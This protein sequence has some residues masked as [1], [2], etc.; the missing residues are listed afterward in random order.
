MVDD[1]DGEMKTWLEGSAFRTMELNPGDVMSDNKIET[2]IYFDLMGNDNL[3]G[4]PKNLVDAWGKS[5]VAPLTQIA[6]HQLAAA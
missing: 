5:I 1:R 4:P 2:L 6:Q 3:I